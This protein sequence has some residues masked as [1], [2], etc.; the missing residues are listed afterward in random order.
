M[1][2]KDGKLVL[3][4]RRM[5]LGEPDASG[6]RKPV[7]VPN[8]EFETIADTV[9]AAIGQRTNAP[10]NIPVNK[11]GSSLPT[12]KCQLTAFAVIFEKSPRKLN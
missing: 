1:E 6:R 11:Q 3:T 2:K 5:E 4:C 10:S 8:S 9:I 12:D 7:E